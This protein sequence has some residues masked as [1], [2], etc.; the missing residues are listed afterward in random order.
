MNIEITAFAKRQYSEDFAGT[1]VT[2]EMVVQLI[3]LAKAPYLIHA[4]YADFCKIIT[5]SNQKKQ[6]YHFPT[7]SSN[8]VSRKE[9]RQQGAVFHTAYEA[10]TEEELPILT[11]WVTGIEKKTAPFVHIIVYSRDQLEKENDII[12]ADWGIVSINGSTQS[13]LEPM[14]PI[15]AMRNALGV[16]EGGSGVPLDRKAYQKSVIFSM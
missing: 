5:I 6:E 1:H 9:A 15:T 14:K 4:G 11:E 8:V 13:K 2:P 3:E 12:T 7:I 16:Q 10:R